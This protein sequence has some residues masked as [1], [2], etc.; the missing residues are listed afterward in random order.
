MINHLDLLMEVLLGTIGHSESLTPKFEDGYGWSDSGFT[1]IGRKRLRMLTR[2]ITIIEEE[3]I[4]GD[5]VEAGTWRGGAVA[6]MAANL[7]TGSRRTV[8]G[9]DTFEGMPTPTHPLDLGTTYHRQEA[10]KAWRIDVERLLMHL[11]LSGRVVLV[12]G[13]F[14][15]TLRHVSGPLSLIRLDGDLYESTM[16]A[17]VALYPKLSPGGF[18]VV[19][20]Y[21][22]I[23]Q[24]K[25]AVTEYRSLYEIV[26]PIQT[27]DWTGVWW[28]KR[29]REY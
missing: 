12:Q 7:P 21:N 28:R 24:C 23:T 27:I 16:D 1:M 4:P 18:C 19:D 8:W 2:A 9:A 5:L 11:K 13:L 17:L 3:K 26:E 22:S 14:K 15:D 10:L 29:L 25:Q 20:D 6:W